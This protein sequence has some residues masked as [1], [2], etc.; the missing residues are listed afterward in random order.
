MNQIPRVG[1]PRSTPLVPPGAI[2]SGC[3]EIGAAGFFCQEPVSLTMHIEMDLM[4]VSDGTCK[5]GFHPAVIA[6]DW[7]AEEAVQEQEAFCPPA[8]APLVE[9]TPS[10]PSAVD[11][12]PATS[13]S[14]RCTPPRPA[15]VPALEVPLR[16]LAN[17]WKLSSDLFEGD[18][19]LTTERAL[20]LS[21]RRDFL[22][23]LHD[24]EA[25]MLWFEEHAR[26]VPKCK[27]GKR[28]ATRLAA[29]AASARH[30]ST[31]APG[32]QPSLLNQERSKTM[33]GAKKKL[34]VKPDA[35]TRPR[36]RAP[37]GAAPMLPVSH[38]FASL[39]PTV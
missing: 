3:P 35:A 19:A 33:R 21:S 25:S 32:E 22:E 37:L 27:K 5:V 30:L 17:D 1:P 38:A 8:P 4:I 10:T 12:L 14:S 18:R 16:S 20:L 28:K 15:A 34:P 13:N 2:P 7:L 9:V 24:L 23:R 11:A 36:K 31:L 29:S 26:K 39:V 6:A